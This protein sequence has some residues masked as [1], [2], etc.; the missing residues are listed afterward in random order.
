L[1]IKNSTGLI[2]AWGFS[3]KG[4]RIVFFYSKTSFSWVS[5]SLCVRANN[6]VSKISNYFSGN[7]RPFKLWTSGSFLGAQSVPRW[8]ATGD[9]INVT[10]FKWG[11]SAGTLPSTDVTKYLTVISMDTSA[12]YLVNV[13]DTLKD[14]T[15]PLCEEY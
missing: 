9:P 5:W 15:Y 4:N 6:V 8:C 2:F 1:E 14:K 13:V 3:L 12:D 7:V 11:P 10:A